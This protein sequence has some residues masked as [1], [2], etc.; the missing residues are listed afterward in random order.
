MRIALDTGVL[1]RTNVK[2][3]G[4]ARRLLERI[5]HGPHGLVLSEFLLTETT[6]VL[7]YPRLQK[8][9]QLTPADI[10][11]H[12][13]RLRARSDIVSAAVYKPVVL[14]DPTTTL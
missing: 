14:T 8:R 9:Y 4:P 6:R 12:V 1:V 5:L 3:T 13:D 2:A 7:G 10:A 11:E